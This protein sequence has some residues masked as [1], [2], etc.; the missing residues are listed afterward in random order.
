[1][2]QTIFTLL[3][4]LSLPSLVIG[5]S[6]DQSFENPSEFTDKQM[7]D[8]K[9]FE[10]SGIKDR[11]IKEG[12]AGL[13]DCKEDDEGFPIEMVIGKAYAL[14]GMMSGGGGLM[15]TLTKKP[16][17]AKGAAEGT[18]GAEGAAKGT[19]GA[20]Q[21]A[22]GAAQ[23]AEGAAKG[24]EGAAKAGEKAETQPD[25][26]MMV[27]MGYETLGG[28][29]QD[30][31]QKKAEKKNQEIQDTQVQALLNLKE[32]HKA[33]K[34]TANW[35][36]AIYGGVTACYVGMA[37]TGEIA[38]DWKY[39]AKLGGATALTTLY[40]KKA[41][42]HDKAAKKVQLV[43]D[44]L[45][46]AGECNPWTKTKCFCS[47]PTSKERFP[48]NY[49]EVCVLNGGNFDTPKVATGCGAVV[50][51]KLTFDENCKCKETNSCMKSNLKTYNPQF[52]V[53]TNYMNEANKAFDLLNSGMYDEGK[54]AA[55]SFAAGAMAKKVKGKLNSRSIP[56]VAL[57]DEQKK[58]AA[59]L[60]A[61]VPAPLASVA[62]ASNSNYTGGIKESAGNSA[63]TLNKLPSSLKEKLADTRIKANYRQG[64][65]GGSFN[66][67][68]ERPDFSFGFPKVGQEESSS[69]T[70]VLSF[71]EQAISKA[72]VNNTPETPIF[73]IISNRYRRSGWGK[74]EA[75][76]E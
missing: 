31:L 33:R 8:A 10:H 76:K 20:A 65:G 53:A 12:C 40:I 3:I 35:Q 74:L 18:E 19:E 43:I 46:K 60:A 5:Q 23:G 36:S 16:E 75:E 25:Y 68:S 28:V 71:A 64:N 45:P 26:C 57:N 48:A 69:G 67:K 13:N 44:S 4:L 38:T 42:K 6:L 51:G 52:S 66:S 21:G 55:V 32:N 73:D 17:V 62:A 15:P 24:A 14:L 29:I 9:T 11:V 2:K 34:T 22:E 1:M 59:E 47:E 30:H 61:Y 50:G 49:Q 72:D 7:S 58:I 70:E 41:N 37:F 56:R 39:W 54:V 27:A 63:S